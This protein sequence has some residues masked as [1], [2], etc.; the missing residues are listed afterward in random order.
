MIRMITSW[1][2]G[3]Y[4]ALLTVVTK[5]CILWLQHGTLDRCY[6]LS[7]NCNHSPPSCLSGLATLRATALVAGQTGTQSGCTES[8]TASA[9]ANENQIH[10]CCRSS[11]VASPFYQWT[12]VRLIHSSSLHLW[13]GLQMSTRMQCQS[14]MLPPQK[15]STLRRWPPTRSGQ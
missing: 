2:F 5:S 1:S 6:C 11:E 12:R 8:L 4:R 10:S 3:C 9:P 7:C 14:E 15:E 13:R